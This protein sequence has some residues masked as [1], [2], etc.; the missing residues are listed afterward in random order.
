MEL[1]EI[2][3]MCHQIA[4]DHGWWVQSREDGTCIALMMSELAEALEEMRGANNKNAVGMELGD[5]C[6]RIF[7]YAK[8]Y[9]IDLQDCILRKCEINKNRPMRHGK[10]F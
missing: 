8:R 2:I 4:L 1:N 7:D 6:I 3:D 10:R 9:D 5:V